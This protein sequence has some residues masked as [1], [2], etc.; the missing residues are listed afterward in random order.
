M[1]KKAPGFDVWLLASQRVYRAV[2]FDVLTDWIQQGR[3]TAVDKCRPT[4]Q[5]DWR[6]I[7]ESRA[8]AA[9]LPSA[10]PRV[11]D[12]AAEAYEP[13]A[14]ATL[15]IRHRYDDDD[16]DVDMIPLIDISLVLLIFFMMTSTVAISGADIETPTTYNGS[17]LTTGTDVIWLGADKGPDGAAVYSIGLGNSPADDADRNLTLA[18]VVKRLKAELDKSRGLPVRIAGHRGLPFGAIQA[19]TSEVEKE[20]GP[21]RVTEIKA[22]VSERSS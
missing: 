20:R 6:T 11:A 5:G 8:L 9:F 21:G 12:D 1:A 22:E 3:V 18:Q 19:L 2:P 16:D 15:P 17:Q 14:V 13:I 7:G 4:G 10:E